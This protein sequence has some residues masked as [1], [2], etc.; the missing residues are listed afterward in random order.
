MEELIDNVRGFTIK[1]YAELLRYLGKIYKIIPLRG[2]TH[3]SAPYLAL[4]HDVDYSASSALKMAELERELGV[5]ATYFVLF[6]D[7]FYNLHERRYA[8]TMKRISSLGHEIGLHYDPSQYGSY[9]N[10]LERT[11]RIEI[12]QLE[13]MTGKKVYSIARHGPWDRD[14]FTKVKGL[15]NANDPRWRGDLFIHDSLRA[16]TPFE[17][18]STLFTNPPRRVQLLVHPEY[19]KEEKIDRRMLLDNF[20]KVR[21]EEN[22]NFKKELEKW[23]VKD[24]TVIEYDAQVA[25]SRNSLAQ[26]PNKPELAPRKNEP[27]QSKELLR[28]YI[29]NTS[30]GWKLHKV[31]EAVRSL[32]ARNK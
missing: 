8:Q 10:N 13:N 7:R 24:P 31:T 26:P 12:A 19:W 20:F 21:D 2:L 4:R 9:G 17:A 6:S 29:I 11:L 23:W 15:I 32:R 5:T 14:P 27:Q 22:R 16:W 30:I 28:W 1:G 18:L 3:V 25:N